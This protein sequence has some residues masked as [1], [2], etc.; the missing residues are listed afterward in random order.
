[1]GAQRSEEKFTTRCPCHRPS[2]PPSV[3]SSRASHSASHCPIVCVYKLHV[4]TYL[5]AGELRVPARGRCQ[6]VQDGGRV[7][8]KSWSV[9]TSSSQQQQ[10]RGSFLYRGSTSPVVALASHGGRESPSSLASLSRNSSFT[11]PSNSVADAQSL[12]LSPQ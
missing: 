3:P 4:L 7:D 8:R 6:D 10:R 1:M 5:L 12:Q 11:G 2:D 9:M